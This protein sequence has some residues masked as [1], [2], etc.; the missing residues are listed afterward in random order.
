MDRHL[1]NHWAIE[2]TFQKIEKYAQVVALR[3]FEILVLVLHQSEIQE[4][5]AKNQTYEPW[6]EIV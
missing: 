2:S 4:I 5:N 1:D 3:I 6:Q